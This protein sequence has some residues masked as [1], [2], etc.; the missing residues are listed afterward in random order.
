MVSIITSKQDQT[1][2]AVL[3]VLLYFEMFSHPL[4]VTEVFQYANWGDATEIEYT[5]Q[6]LVAQGF[7]FEKEGFYMTQNKPEWVEKRHECNRRADEFLPIA[8]RKAR[9]IASFPFVRGVFISGSLSKHSMSADSDIDFF[10]ITK[11]ERLWLSRTLMMLYKKVFLLNSHKYFCINYFIDTNHLEIEEKNLFTATETVTLL[12]MYGNEWYEKFHTANQWAYHQYPHFSKKGNGLVA[13]TTNF[14][15]KNTC[16]WL[17]SGWLGEQLDGLS[18]RITMWF[19]QRKF[20]L[21]DK[22]IFDVALKSRKY[23]S[24]HH[25]QHFQ[26]KVLRSFEDKWVAMQ[27]RLSKRENVPQ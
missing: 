27:Q 4:M 5:L 16:E 6:M 19:W 13:D 23:V 3:K 26:H 15:W 7:V 17:L 24:K 10:I 25:P 2:N 8:Q 1:E 12:P 14:W 21:M 11:A 20:S 9:F 22:K 18:M